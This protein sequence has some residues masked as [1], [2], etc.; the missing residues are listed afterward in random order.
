MEVIEGAP[1]AEYGD[2]DSL[3]I[4]VNT[5][6]GL[7]VSQPHGDVTASWRYDSGLVAG[8]VPCAGG[9]CA[10]RPLGGDTVVDASIITPDQQFQAGL[11]CGSVHA[12]PTTP[13]SPNSVYAAIAVWFESHQHTRP[14][15]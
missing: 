14:R 1:P 2:K 9:N 12:T 15:H 6:S 3:V 10:N 4:V 13:I 7:G 8:P 5:R 11:F